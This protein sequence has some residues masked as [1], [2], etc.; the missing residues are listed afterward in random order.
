LVGII[1]FCTY[2]P[3]YRLPRDLIAEQWGTKSIGGAKAIANYDQDALT[4]A[5]EVAWNLV[6]QDETKLPH[7]GLY[8]ASTTAPYW[9]RASSSFIAAAC[10]LRDE[11][12]TV[13]F[14]GTL[15]CGTAALR[16]ALNAV[17]AGANRK[18]IVAVSD[19]RD[20]APESVEEQQFGD[21]A[22]GLC[23]GSEGVIAELIAHGSRSDDFH[24]EWRRD[25]DSY[26][27]V[28]ASRYSLERGYI[29][30]T[31][32][33][34]KHILDLA[35]LKP[36][37]IAHLAL[38]SPDG[39]SHIIAAKK[40]G[41]DISQLVDVPIA[42][43]GLTGAPLPITLLCNAL[44]KAK[45]ADFVLTISHGDGADAVLFRVTDQKLKRRHIPKTASP[46]AIPTYSV[47]RK[48]REF[49]RT[50]IEDGAVI[51]N[52]TLEQEERQHVR[53][54][55]TR[56]PKC[57][58]VQFPLTAVCVQCQNRSGL[59][60]TRMLRRGTV[61]TFTK[62]YLY[63]APVSPVVVGVIE[64]EDGAR[65]YCQLTDVDAET[66]GIGTKVQ[67]TLRRLKDGGRM[68]H[69]YWKCRPVEDDESV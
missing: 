55:A 9:Q 42:N 24:D 59:E 69:Y 13:D 48:L 5:F 60:E 44:E 29:A 16:A 17:V 58:T 31:V 63:S 22:A 62:D 40:L 39:R 28:L 11:I 30:N 27:S 52:V 33:I 65:F 12:E 35:S 34:G 41:F 7:D 25:K 37:D 46:I 10:D 56:C 53:L 19:V 23:I 8:F 47:Y 26:V 61:F 50:A 4:M 66:I 38:S 1:D 51:S 32:A 2:I 64:L 6:E 54:H 21:G 20:G 57:N 43:G 14:G 36:K 18:V 45:P 49:S 15:R 3:S 68:H 67:L